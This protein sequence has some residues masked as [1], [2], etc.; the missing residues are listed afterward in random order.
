MPDK[1][2]PQYKDLRDR[3]SLRIFAGLITK[4]IES[5]HSDFSADGRLCLPPIDILAKAA[6]DISDVYIAEKIQ[7]EKAE[8]S[9]AENP[10][11]ADDEEAQG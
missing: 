11:R 10:W 5:E 2:E 8:P 4:L 9:L 1:V 7:R 6:F 3:L